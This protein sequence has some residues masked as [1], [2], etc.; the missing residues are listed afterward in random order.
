MKWYA[1]Y[2]S[3][4][5]NNHIHN[6][7]PSIKS[8]SQIHD[9]EE[10]MRSIDDKLNSQ[11]GGVESPVTQVPLDDDDDNLFALSHVPIVC[12]CTLALDGKGSYGAYIRWQGQLWRLHSMAWAVLACPLAT[13]LSGMFL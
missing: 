7:D 8:K 6:T 10:T 3:P 5:H 2:H 9:E 4:S 1:L 13:K 11:M 12:V